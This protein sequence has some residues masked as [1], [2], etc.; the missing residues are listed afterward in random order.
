MI[1]SLKIDIEREREIIR[2]ILF[3]IDQIESREL[4]YMTKDDSRLVN[5]TINSLL[6]QLKILNNSIPELVKDISLTQKLTEKQKP[7]ISEVKNLHPSL[8]KDEEKLVSIRSED[9]SRYLKELSISRELINKLKNKKES[10]KKGVQNKK[11]SEFVKLANRF[12]FKYSLQLAD[13]M[14]ILKKD[15]QK[16]N[17]QIMH[18]SYISLM[19][20]IT[21]IALIVSIPIFIISMFLLPGG[22]L[23]SLIKLIWI[24]PGLPLLTFGFMYFYPKTE[25]SSL[26]KKIE[27]ELPFVTINMAA[28]AGSKIE[29]SNIFRIVVEGEESPNTKQEFKKILNQINLYGYD[30]VSAL[31]SV[32]KTTSSTKLSELL[33]GL[34]STI[35]SG[36]NLIEFLNNRSESLMLDYRLEME[37]Y[38][39]NAETMM[40]I[41]ISIVVAAPMIL[42]LMLIMIS[43]S[44]LSF[45]LSLNMMVALILLAVALINVVFLI[46]LHM[47][48]TGF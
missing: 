14:Y 47:R 45:G 26:K 32:A 9:K 42:M 1:D 3:L 23:S 31:K 15:L 28:I 8:V 18:T 19:F 38:T 6:N 24:I 41:Y 30:L 21:A 37:K 22:F 44:G 17:F 40:N 20:L 7:R 27:R 16:G 39:K 35:Y 34:A 46:F 11:A 5:D 36:G 33:N 10:E 48:Q 29:P 25:A 13:K 43:I 2:E 4:V 12:F